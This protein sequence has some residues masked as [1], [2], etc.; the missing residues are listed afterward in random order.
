MPDQI[1]I[2]KKKCCWPWI[3][4]LLLLAGFLA[5]S[6]GDYLVARENVRTTISESTLPLTSDNVYSEIQRD[7]LRPIFIAS[8]MASDTFLR[9]WVLGGELDQSSIVRYLHEI[10]IE[11]GTITSFFVSNKS[12]NYYYAHGL[13][14]S[15]SED[16]PRD[17]WYF[18]VRDME[19]PYEINVD[20]DMANQDEMT[21]FINYRTKDY[22]G[23]FIGATGVG[24]TVNR[25]NHLISRY[26][27]KYDRQIYF[28]D[29]SGTLVLRPS[30]SP[31]L[32]YNNLQ[33]IEGLAGHVESLL[34][35]T[36]ESITY[37]RGND[38]RIMNS[39]FVP[40]LDWYLIVEQSEASMLAPLRRQLHV[41][42]L[43]A[44]LTTAIVAATCIF[45]VRTHEHGI[46]KQHRELIENAQIIER[47]QATVKDKTAEL[48]AANHK[49]QRLNHEKDDFLNIVAHDLRNPLN[50]IIGFSEMTQSDLPPE[51]PIKEALVYIQRSGEEMVNL[52]NELLDIS[53]IEASP[54]S[55]E[56]LP[57]VWNAVIQQA[58]QRFE[59]DAARKHIEVK[60][61]LGAT[62]GTSVQGVEEWLGIVVNNLLSNAVKYTPEYGKVTVQTE[63][64]EDRV[65]TRIQD[66]GPGINREEQ[67]KLFQK[68][69]RLSARPTG[70][71]HS[72]GLGL[73]IVKKMCERLDISVR[74]ESALGQGATFILEQKL[75]V[76]DSRG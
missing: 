60:C 58:I 75:T 6:I 53:R 45:A 34:D 28:V 38:R 56:K 32:R 51:S 43:T 65:I 2:F 71:E 72:T 35:G 23:N 49:L 61:Q 63:C 66:N 15:V 52:I 3:I 64:R 5:N 29:S 30:N 19:T 13:L 33:E 44:L 12:L 39:R 17:K 67:A 69:V 76:G 1:L 59:Q 10:K 22:A 55:F 18:R 24:L 57:V 54:E 41:N 4:C 36:A 14:K 74:V 26:E 50:S 21:I 48:E 16:D 8:M 20:P 40:E 42:L 11:Y 46:E 62:E 27:A 68:F 9:D 31:M 25:M 7:L 73:Y 37:V 70:N 47:Q